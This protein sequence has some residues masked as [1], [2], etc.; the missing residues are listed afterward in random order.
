MNC[1]QSNRERE[2]D[3]LDYPNNESGHRQWWWIDGFRSCF[4]LCLTLVINTIVDAL[5]F[6]FFRESGWVMQW[7]ALLPFAWN[8]NKNEI[9]SAAWR[10]ISTPPTLH[11][12]AREVLEQRPWRNAFKIR[13]NTDRPVIP[14]IYFL[15]PKVT[16]ASHVCWLLIVGNSRTTGAGQGSGQSVRHWTS[17]RCSA[18]ARATRLI[19]WALPAQSEFTFQTSDVASNR[20][21]TLDRR[22]PA[23]LVEQWST[24][25]QVQ[26]D[27]HAW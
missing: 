25:L 17:P 13:R 27:R 12:R 20:R 19:S 14:H 3:K 1:C 8:G 7:V 18:P 6:S 11:S 9:R 21:F 4:L 22:T 2:R 10:W 26:P 23:K 16:H 15:S 5:V 24:Q